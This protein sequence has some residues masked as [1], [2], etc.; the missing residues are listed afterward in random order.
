MH[1]PGWPSLL[2]LAYILL[3]LPW[4]ALQSAR[5]LAAGP[6][7]R[8]QMQLPSRTAIWTRAIILEGVMLVFALAVGAGFG[9][10]PFYG[11]STIGFVEVGAAVLALGLCFLLR[12]I[13]RA[14][15]SEQER[16][17]LLVFRIAPR[18][19]QE[20]ALWIVTVV[21]ASVTEEIVYRGVAMSILWYM[22]GNAWIA[23]LIS[24][25][26]FAGAHW[27]QGAKSGVVIF[28]IGLVMQGLVAVTATLVLAMIIHALYDLVAGY[29][30]AREA[31]RFDSESPV[32]AQGAAS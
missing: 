29:L 12:F 32:Q 2:F 9:F 25:I 21:F 11:V 23:A 28:F 20:W 18:T 30:I 3:L 10:E 5:R 24:A 4:M 14:L 6:E 31:R 19:G 15:R 26:G 16:R 1:I 13:V 27:T 17:K 22:L 7:G 8:P